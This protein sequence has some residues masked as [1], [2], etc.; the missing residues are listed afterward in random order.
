MKEL[1]KE[2]IEAITN[3]KVLALTNQFSA[4]PGAIEHWQTVANKMEAALWD[5]KDLLRLR[6]DISKLKKEK[7][8]LQAELKKPESDF[9]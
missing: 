2:V 3:I 7:K 6:E 1:V 4:L 9:I 5:Q 8:S